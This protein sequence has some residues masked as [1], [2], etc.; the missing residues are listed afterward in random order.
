MPEKPKIR[1]GVEALTT[2]QCRYML[3]KLGK[4]HSGLNK[5]QM[6]QLINALIGQTPNP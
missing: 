5:R 6:H 2:A 3:N 1:L 4:D